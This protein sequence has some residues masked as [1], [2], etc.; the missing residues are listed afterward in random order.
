M[1]QASLRIAIATL[2]LYKSAMVSANQPKATIPLFL[3]HQQ[4][5]I[6][7]NQ[8]QQGVLPSLEED[9]ASHWISKGLFE[10]SEENRRKLSERPIQ[11]EQ[12]D[13]CF[14]EG[15]GCTECWIDRY[16]QIVEFK[17]PDFCGNGKILLVDF[18]YPNDTMA[19]MAQQV[20]LLRTRKT[21]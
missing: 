4:E 7:S 1:I 20:S 17:C 5:G 10:D 15:D 9:Y 8:K 11:P 19:I 3:Q 14:F 18:M 13:V 6:L 16:Y 2:A 12:L 21:L